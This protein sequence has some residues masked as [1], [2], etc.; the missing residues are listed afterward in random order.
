MAAIKYYPLADLQLPNDPLEATCLTAWNIRKD[1]AKEVDHF[2]VTVYC[3]PKKKKFHRHVYGLILP[4]QDSPRKLIHFTYLFEGN[5]SVKD[6]EET[7][8]APTFI[9]RFCLMPE[10]DVAE[11][12]WGYPDCIYWRENRWIKSK[13]Q[14]WRALT[15]KTI[16]DIPPR[17]ETFKEVM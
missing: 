16:S 13:D 14:L 10:P 3:K 8:E 17:E 15:Y 6:P 12:L 4:K 7:F 2:L 1:W 9:G 5:P 11:Y